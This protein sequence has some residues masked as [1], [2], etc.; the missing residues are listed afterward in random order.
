MFETSVARNVVVPVE[1]STWQTALRSAAGGG[2][3]PSLGTDVKVSGVTC[4]FGPAS[5]RWSLRNCA[6]SVNWVVMLSIS[7]S[8]VAGSTLSR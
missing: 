3:E 8:A 4:P 1:A 2:V 5:W 6:R 7:A